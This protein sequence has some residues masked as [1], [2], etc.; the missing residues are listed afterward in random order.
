MRTIQILFAAALMLFAATALAAKKDKV[1]ICHVGNEEGPAGEVY[2]PAC[3]PEEAND[4]FC[5]DAGKIDLILVSGNANHLGNGSH[6]YDGISDYEPGDVGASGDGTED[7]NGD[8]VDDGCEPPEICPCWD[9]VELLSVTAEN[10][11]PAGSCS[12]GSNL[13]LNAVIQND[14]TSPGVEGG[15]AAQILL[16]DVIDG[17]CLTRDFEP[18]FLEIS[19]E[20]TAS[21]IAQ[22]A[23]RCAAIGD[24]IAPPP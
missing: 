20:E 18:F 3:V 14:F 12:V 4:Y 24:P 7:S 1:L 19:V 11:L 21:C 5:A 15:F 23:A 22:I 8:G 13:P 2:H 16:D 17:V 9:E 10:N 6:M